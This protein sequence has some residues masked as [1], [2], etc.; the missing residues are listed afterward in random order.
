[1]LGNER[2]AELKVPSLMWPSK[3]PERR[4]CAVRQ[5]FRDEVERLMDKNPPCVRQTQRRILKQRDVAHNQVASS[6]VNWGR[7]R[8]LL[9]GRRSGLGPLAIASM[10]SG[11]DGVRHCAALIS[12][13]SWTKAK[14]AVVERRLATR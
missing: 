4:S 8:G 1:M 7:P 14:A 2:G 9:A 6:V 12:A 13:Q 5:W 10:M 3:R 11:K